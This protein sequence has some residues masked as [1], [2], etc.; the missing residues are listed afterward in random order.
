MFFPDQFFGDGG[1]DLIKGRNLS[2]RLFG[3]DGNDLILGDRGM[4]VLKLESMGA[5]I[6]QDD[7]QS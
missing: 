2:D 3:G 4:L 1:D 5:E 6:P 7:G